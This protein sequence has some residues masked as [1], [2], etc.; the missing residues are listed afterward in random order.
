MR[1][2]IMQHPLSP[3]SALLPIAGQ[4]L[5]ARQLEWLREQHV[6]QIAIEVSSAETAVTRWL[7][8]HPVFAEQV[9]RPG[10]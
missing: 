2:V 7:D 9:I 6:E 8:E 3:N 4:P 1:A 5:L 10:R